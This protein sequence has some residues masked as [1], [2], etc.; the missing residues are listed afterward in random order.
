MESVWNTITK[1]TMVQL[2]KLGIDIKFGN[3]ESSSDRYVKAKT[4]ISGCY[5][6]FARRKTDSAVWIELE[7]KP[8]KGQP[9]DDLFQYLQINKKQIEESLGSPIEITINGEHRR[10]STFLKDT[11]IPI[12]KDCVEKMVPFVSTLLPYLIQFNNG[13]I[14]TLKLKSSIINSLNEYPNDKDIENAYKKL[15]STIG[16]DVDRELLLDQIE[17][18]FKEQARTLESDWRI[19]TKDKINSQIQK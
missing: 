3:P 12:L 6:A 14:N 2:S 5:W 8:K 7:L 10:V 11:N 16:E 19:K 13:E 15:V 4:G 18:N 9:Q 17:K 1:E